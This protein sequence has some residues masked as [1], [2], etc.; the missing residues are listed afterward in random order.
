M[1]ESKLI[2]HVLRV[3]AGA[4]N[5]TAKEVFTALSAEGLGEITLAAVKKACSKA[6]KQQAQ[7][8]PAVTEPS[9]AAAAP[10]GTAWARRAG[11]CALRC[12]LC[13]APFFFGWVV[14]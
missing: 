2:A 7:A 12:L 9:E 14:C 5:M 11:L 13:C 8:A 3:R 6:S 10:S 4:E 1:E